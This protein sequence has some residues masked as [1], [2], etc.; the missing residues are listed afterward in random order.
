MEK[1][2]IFKKKLK[3]LIW[4]GVIGVFYQKKL[5]IK[6]LMRFYQVKIVKKL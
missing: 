3:V 5:A 4:L 1:V 6:Y 2:K